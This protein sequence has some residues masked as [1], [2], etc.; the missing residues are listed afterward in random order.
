MW[1]AVLL[2][3]TPSYAQIQLKEGSRIGRT[4]QVFKENI[5]RPLAAILTLN[6]IAH[7]VGAVGVGDQ[8]AKI[9]AHTHPTIT[10]IVVPVVMTLAI[11]VLSELI[12][13]TIGA[14]FWK[15][16]AP[17]TVRSLSLVIKLLYPLV[18]FS[19][20]ITKALKK[21]KSESVLS[22]TD[23]LAMAEIGEKQ[24]VFKP[25]ES[26][27]IT[28]LLKFDTVRAKDVM[29]PRVVVTSAPADIRIRQFFEA[30]RNLRFSRIPLYR[31]D[32][33][34][35]VTGYVLKD[36]LLA[37]LAEK[38]EDVPLCSFE[39]H[40]VTVEETFPIPQLFDFFLKKREHIAMV[41]DA[42]GGMSGIV[43]ME[44][45]I[46]TLI[47]MEIVDESDQTEDMQALARKNW[48]KR[49]KAS[50]LIEA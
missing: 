39:R 33:P 19:Q 1:E 32:S 3:V 35:H 24:G 40:L 13:K 25:R 22:R 30:N 48:Q 12:P 50:G 42:F 11:L 45:V 34:D 10:S 17:F 6:T 46:E 8:A 41:V 29:T 49:A 43:T 18:W 44:D 14:N 47:G 38:K 28:N 9:W 15:E 37:S 36:D 4:L 2:S 7:T 27:I 23:F 26:S 31:A 21:D 5:D 20:F 16:L